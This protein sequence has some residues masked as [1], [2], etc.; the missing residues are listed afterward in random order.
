MY[1]RIQEGMNGANG[2]RA[3]MIRTE[4]N[5]G[6]VQIGHHEFYHMFLSPNADE[7]NQL[8]TPKQG[9]SI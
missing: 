7:S 8:A 1:A 3:G 6:I 4:G 9:A 2:S 5:Q